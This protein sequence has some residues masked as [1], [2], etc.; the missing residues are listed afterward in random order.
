MLILCYLIVAASFF[1]HVDPSNGEYLL[2]ESFSQSPLG[3]GVIY[4]DIS[5]INELCFSSQKIE[6]LLFLGFW[7]EKQKHAFQLL[8]VH[9][10]CLF[11]LSKTKIHLLIISC[12]VLESQENESLISKMSKKVHM[13]IVL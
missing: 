9:F 3:V 8:L 2:L 1:V 6:N 11:Y 7:K 4:S 5:F 13:L 12:I 10:S